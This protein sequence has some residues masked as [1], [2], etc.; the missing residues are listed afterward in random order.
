MIGLSFDIFSPLLQV[1]PEEYAAITS[2][3]MHVGNT[4]V[5]PAY[6]NITHHKKWAIPWM[7][8]NVE[9]SV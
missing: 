9:K 6:M 5:D 4:P 3:D 1:L 7:E 8:V 2:I